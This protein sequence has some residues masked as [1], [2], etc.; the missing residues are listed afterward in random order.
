MCMCRRISVLCLIHTWKV[1]LDWLSRWVKGWKFYNP[2]TKCTIISEHADF[3]ERHFMASKMSPNVPGVP[4]CTDHLGG[5]IDD[6]DDSDGED[7]PPLHV[8]G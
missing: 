2:T 4:P 1:H 8:Q 5:L 3:D 6:S 7:L